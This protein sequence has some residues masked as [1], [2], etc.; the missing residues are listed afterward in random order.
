MTPQII[1]ILCLLALAIIFFAWERFSP[2]VVALGLLLVLAFSGFLSIEEVFSGFANPAV[3]TVWAVYIISEALFRTGVADYLGKQLIYLGGN[4]ETRLIIAIMLLSGG[5][6][7]FMNNVGAT[8]ILLPAVVNVSNKMGLSPGKL[9]IP[10]AFS[11]LMGGNL[12]LIGTPPNILAAN[13][14]MG[15]EGLAFNFFDFA[16]M[17]LIIL[18]SGILYMVFIG[19]HLLPQTKENQNLTHSYQLRDYTTELYVPEHST[20]VGKTLAQSKLGAQYDLTVL[21]KLAR[22]GASPYLSAAQRWAVSPD[23]IIEAHDI[24]LVKGKLESILQLR[25]SKAMRIRAEVK[26]SDERLKNQ[27]ESIAEV[28][29]AA[30]SGL[31]EKTLAEV[32]FRERNKVN[33]LAIWRNEHA[34]RQKLA[35]TPLHLG[36]VLLVQGPKE[37]I[38]AFSQNSGLIVTGAISHQAPKSRQAPLALGI[39]ALLV[40]SVT[41]GLVHISVAALSA[42]LLLVLLNILSM[43]EAYQAIQWRSIF[44]IAGMLPIGIAMEKTGTGRLFGGT[45]CAI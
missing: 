16:P 28:I 10:L 41:G 33:V 22:P 29:I 3:V 37:N 36:D 27:R 25:E 4:S 20:L 45:N 14:L 26:L 40:I 21:S 34:I 17:G 8:A 11:S 13:I 9:L 7:A 23:E 2:D 42:A 39:L 5:I 12:T 44:L 15:Y 35:D 32:R 1:F 19:R 30:R 24:F 43:D 6:S 38:A 18:S 31:S